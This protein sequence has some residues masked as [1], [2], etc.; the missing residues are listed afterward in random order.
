MTGQPT[1]IGMSC[2]VRGSVAACPA[3]RT[4]EAAIADARPLITG[5]TSF[6]SVQIAAT[7][8]VPAPTKR[9]LWLHVDGHPRPHRRSRRSRSSAARPRPQPISAPARIATPTHRPTRC[10]TA[11]KAIDRLKSKPRDRALAVAAE[12][13]VL[14]DIGGEGA[15]R[16]DS[17]N[18]AALIAP[19]TTASSPAR[20]SSAASRWRRLPPPPT[21]STS[22]QATPS[23]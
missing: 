17:A 6:A 1:P 23:G 22:A 12:A 3:L 15:R 19:Q 14:H 10:P 7:P 20:F 11:N 2:S 16:D 8:I 5:L 21:F 18:T 13:E 9:T 4:R